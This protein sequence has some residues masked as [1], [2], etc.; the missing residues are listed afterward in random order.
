MSG[1]MDTPGRW[2]RNFDLIRVRAPPELTSFLSPPRFSLTCARRWDSSVQTF[3]IAMFVACMAVCFPVRPTR[4]KA[5]QRQRP[6]LA[7][8]LLTSCLC[9]QCEIVVFSTLHAPTLLGPRTPCCKLCP[10]RCCPLR[11]GPQLLACVGLPGFYF[12]T[13][14]GI[15]LSINHFLAHGWVSPPVIGLFA[16]GLSVA[17]NPYCFHRIS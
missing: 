15:F 3:S 10:H 13:L 5:R 14:V 9:V 1:S 12:W 2:A 6:P 17:I 11:V 16:Q 8:P 4:F 7:S